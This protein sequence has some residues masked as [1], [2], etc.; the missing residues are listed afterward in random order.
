MGS[1]R[2]SPPSLPALTRKRPGWVQPPSP[3]LAPGTPAAFPSALSSS[4]EKWVDASQPATDPPPE[5][6]H[7]RGL[8]VWPGAPRCRRGR[9]LGRAVGQVHQEATRER[10]E[11]GLAARVTVGLHAHAV[12][13][14]GG[15]TEPHFPRL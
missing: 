9:P 12:L 4:S 15:L 14:G 8:G 3:V 2:L 5:T 1:P 11:H 13:P 10:L 6:P 7:Q